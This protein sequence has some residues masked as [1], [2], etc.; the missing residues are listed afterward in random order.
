[1]DA[2]AGGQEAQ[3]TL[4][5]ATYGA[6][7]ERLARGYE[8]DPELRRDLLQDI[9]VALWRS[10][11]IFDAAC[12]LRTWVYRVAHNTG[13]THV[14]KRKRV[15]AAALTSLDALAAQPDTDNPEQTTGN[16]HA[17][18]RLL[19]LIQTLRPPDRQVM[20]LYLEGLDAAGIGEV[21]GLSAG[22][23]AS[24]IHRIKSILAQRFQQG[25]QA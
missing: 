8:A 1:M 19:G 3:Y 22:A 25:G 10:F 12:S 14:L 16:R 2:T 7:L 18:A 15:N 23:I 6:A 24:R 13:A 5:A 21:T 11:A 20:L 4:A 17:L 9:H